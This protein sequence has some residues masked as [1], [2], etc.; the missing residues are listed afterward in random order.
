LATASRSNASATK[1][2]PRLA[3]APGRRPE[4]VIYVL[5]PRRARFHGESSGAWLSAPHGTRSARSDRRGSGPLAV[6]H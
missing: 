6:S 5:A 4:A 2:R 1:S 3:L